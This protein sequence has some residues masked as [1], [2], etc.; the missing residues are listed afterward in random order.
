MSNPISNVTSISKSAGAK[1]SPQDTE[2]APELEVDPSFS[3]DANAP[4]PSL[5]VDPEDAAPLDAQAGDSGS[6]ADASASN[7]GSTSAP[8]PAPTA[9][10]Q[11]GGKGLAIFLGLLLAGSVA[12]N[13]KQSRDLAVLNS[14]NEQFELALTAA[15]D[16]IDVETIR[17]ESAEAT[18]GGIDGAVQTVNERVEGLLEALTALS[19]A[20]AK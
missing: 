7:S 17:A 5:E 14:T 16:R 8:A 3:A 11:S 15:V 4:A 2:S 13:V 9:Q 6:S 1:S 12:F 20:T 19:E 18:L 10:K